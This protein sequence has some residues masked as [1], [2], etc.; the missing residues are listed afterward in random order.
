MWVYL[1]VEQWPNAA[2][3][4][5]YVRACVRIYMYTACM[6]YLEECNHYGPTQHNPHVCVVKTMQEI[7]NRWW[8]YKV[9]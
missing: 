1:I 3:Y 4:P 5:L 7:Y 2:A 8:Y 9:E 6:A